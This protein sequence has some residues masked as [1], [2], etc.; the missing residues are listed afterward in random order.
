MKKA[1]ILGILSVSLCMIPTLV[2]A[3]NS[4]NEEGF[5]GKTVH[6]ISN[7]LGMGE[8]NAPE[9]APQNTNSTGSVL[10]ELKEERQEEKKMEPISIGSEYASL[11][12][13][14]DTTSVP[15]IINDYPMVDLLGN[16]K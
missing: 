9:K 16:Q 8:E 10:E 5:F 14:T 6:S 1:T 3:G 7:F 2:Q 15:F 12:S 4:Q 11:E 13:M